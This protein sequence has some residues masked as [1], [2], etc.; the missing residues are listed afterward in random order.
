MHEYDEENDGDGYKSQERRIKERLYSRG[1]VAEEF[2]SSDN[3]YSN[4]EET[5]DNFFISE[6]ESKPTAKVFE[7]PILIGKQLGLDKKYKE[8]EKA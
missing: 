1:M 6:K 5:Y 8:F 3:G 4:T 7:N 2:H